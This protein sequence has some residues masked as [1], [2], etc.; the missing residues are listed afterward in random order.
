MSVTAQGVFGQLGC[1]QLVSYLV[2]DAPTDRVQGPEQWVRRG[3]SRAVVPIATNRHSGWGFGGGA[4][5]AFLCPGQLKE[6]NPMDFVHGKE[7]G[8]KQ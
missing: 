2:C 8:K 5:I 6:F 3:V 7:N 1:L 4:P